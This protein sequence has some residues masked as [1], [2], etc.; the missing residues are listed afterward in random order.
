[1]TIIASIP[2]TLLPATPDN[3]P[4]GE[5]KPQVDVPVG[6]NQM[7][8][9]ILKIGWPGD[10]SQ[11]GYFML[12]YATQGGNW[13]EI[14][15]SDVY[16]VAEDANPLIFSAQLPDTLDGHRRLKL[17]WRLFSARQVSGSIEANVTALKK[18]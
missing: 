5:T 7:L 15:K 18:K 1:M 4:D 3:G 10:E 9:K 13:V 12:S 16:D 17:S 8:V 11:V 2:P 6:T 14:M